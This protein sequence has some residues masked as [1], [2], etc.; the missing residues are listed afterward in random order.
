[1]PGASGG[2]LRVSFS[3]PERAT[4]TCFSQHRYFHLKSGGHGIEKIPDRNHSNGKSANASSKDGYGTSKSSKDAQSSAGS[5]AASSMR[6]SQQGTRKD[7]GKPP[8][9]QQ[10]LVREVSTENIP[11]P[12]KAVLPAPKAAPAP[13]PG[14]PPAPASPPASTAGSP[15]HFPTAPAVE[16]DD[17]DSD[18][19]IVVKNVE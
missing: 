18:S 14:S 5:S 8:A 17:S 7:R 16:K 6:S 13:A 19:D 3:D 1:M 2:V 4:T 12:R 15:P 9:E 11:V 10:N